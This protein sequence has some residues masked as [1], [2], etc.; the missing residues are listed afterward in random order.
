MR[1]IALRGLLG[2]KRST[3]LLWSVVTLAFVFLCVSTTLI[4][5]LQKTDENQRVATYGSWQVLAKTESRAAAQRYAGLVT[6]AGSDPTAAVLPMVNMAGTDYFSGGNTFYFTTWSPEL[7][8]L[9]QLSLKEGRWPAAPNEV[10]LEYAQLTALGLQLGDTFTVASELTLPEKPESLLRHTQAYEQALEQAIAE[11]TAEALQMFR[12]G[13]RSVGS[14]KPNMFFV[15]GAESFFWFWENDGRRLCADLFADAEHPD[16][17]QLQIGDMTEEQFLLAVDHYYRVW[18]GAG[19]LDLQ[20]YFTAEEN[21]Y[22]TGIT[23]LIGAG[24]RSLRVRIQDGS[25]LLT[26][27]TSF[28]VCGVA[29]TVSARWDSGALALPSGFIRAECFAELEAC[30][31]AVLEKYPDFDNVEYSYL[32]LLRGETAADARPLWQAAADVY[33]TG[34]AQVLYTAYGV[35]DETGWQNGV[36]F[37]LGDPGAQRRIPVDGWIRPAVLPDGYVGDA[38]IPVTLLIPKDMVLSG[39]VVDAHVAQEETPEEL[40]RDQPQLESAAVC[41][42]YNGEFYTVP[43]AD[44]AAGNFMVEGMAPIGENHLWPAAAED[45]ADT[46]PVRLNRFAWPSSAEGSGR[47]LVL[48]TVI[49][50]VTTVCAVFQ[51]F[52]SQMRRRLRRIVLMKSIGSTDRQIAA[53]LGWEFVY[54]LTSS[55]PVGVLAGLG[56]AKLA[57]QALSHSQGRAVQ[58]YIAVPVLLAALAA[59]TLALALG[60][61]IPCIM[62]VG[63]PLTGRTVRKK[64]LPPPKKETRQDFLH[65]TLLYLAANR[66]RTLGSAALCVF[67]TLTAVLCLFL[68]VRFL[69]PWREAVQ[70]DGKP[71]YLLR[72]P[73]SMSDRQLEEYLAE[74]EALGV[75]AEVQAWH[76]AQENVI[77]CATPENHEKSPLLDALA[78]GAPVWLGTQEAGASGYPVDLYGIDTASSQYAALAKVV[79]VGAPDAA[80][81]AAGEQVILA[82]PLYRQTP[83][84]VADRLPADAPA[85]ERLAAAGI[86]TSFYAEYDG[87]YQRDTLFQPGDPLSLAAVTRMLVG[88]GG[89]APR[90]EERVVHTDVKVG[91]IVYY[92]PEEGGWPI[93]GSGGAYQIICSPRVI[94]GILPNAIRTRT[95]DEVR[96]LT[97]GN[98]HSGAGHTDFYINGKENLSREDIDTALLIFARSRYMDIEFYHESSEKLLQDAVN[99][100]LLTCLLGLTAAL[101]ALLI[102]A[103]TVTSD[104]EAERGRIGILQALGVSHRR[105]LVRQLCIGLAA[106]GIAAV[107]ANLLLWGGTALF[108]VLSGTVMG[109]LLWHYPWGL[110]A[111]ICAAML[112]LITA[113]YLL[114]MQRLRRYLP[115]EN[116]KSR[117]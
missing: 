83:V 4:T 11:V 103:N 5:S 9:A 3:L 18:G 79:T 7:E 65:V 41:F 109:N 90:F 6:A 51:L 111:G 16:G 114:P 110:H 2:Q 93:A 46:V 88:A 98:F 67:M 108:A 20:K 15:R 78:G 37:G 89:S 115:I 24:Q 39:A 13:V 48:V 80:A 87:T 19:N 91:G 92:F 104:I 27:P 42:T 112:V 40:R 75:C 57:I 52:F 82:V 86:R 70:R 116:I 17:Q 10:V 77:L 107:L 73:Y 94:G 100:I 22:I 117:K 28:T 55:L 53:L 96:S 31:T 97:V 95:D 84:A 33:N 68:G 64:P 14:S 66:G 56:G 69:A 72:A 71:E 8:E 30:R 61:L 21:R 25:M 101:L 34:E 50:F 45:P 85:R 102:F 32:T 44:F 36:R 60:M 47:T 1:K 43:W 54:F 38:A 62:A 74:L 12:D 63:V 29:E 49:L 59:G 26:I 99:N 76:T 106:G 113:L 35:C 81:F 58:M 23:D 105:L